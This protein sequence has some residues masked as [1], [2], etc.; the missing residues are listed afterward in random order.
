[1][2]NNISGSNNYNPWAERNLSPYAQGQT[3]DD[4]YQQIMQDPNLDFYEKKEQ[5]ERL[6]YGPID[7][8]FDSGFEMQYNAQAFIQ[9][10]SG[11]AKLLATEYLDSKVKEIKNNINDYLDKIW[12]DIDLNQYN[13]LSNQASFVD[14][15]SRI[16]EKFEKTSIFLNGFYDEDIKSS[17]LEYY[18]SKK[19][20]I[21]IMTSN[22]LD[23]MWADINVEKV[24]NNLS[25]DFNSLNGI[26]LRI[27][28]KIRDIEALGKELPVGIIKDMVMDYKRDKEQL[29]QPIRDEIKNRISKEF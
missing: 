12:S 10:L 11:E 15:M 5:A 4:Q 18:Y 21:K 28:R 7:E 2:V 27:D 8:I 13:D 20:E 6:L 16:N 17:G 19:N 29:T 22:Y 1:M 9:G 26:S 14:A 23:K 3:I 24:N 25:M